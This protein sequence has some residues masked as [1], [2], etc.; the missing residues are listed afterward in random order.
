MAATHTYIVTSNTA[1]G[2]KA[3]LVGTVDGV[4]VTVEYWVS[5]VQGMTLAQ[6]KNFAAGL[7]LAAAF[8]AAP[9]NVTQ[10]PTGT[11]TQ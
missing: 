1:Q 2:D 4:A 8:P 10:L 6:A 3:T 11:F 5:H 7:M 9:V